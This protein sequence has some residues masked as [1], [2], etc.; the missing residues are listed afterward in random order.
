MGFIDGSGPVLWQEGT[1]EVEQIT[2][3]VDQ[4]DAVEHVNT[5]EE[6]VVGIDQIIID[7]GILTYKCTK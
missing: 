4:G 6:K 1:L 5:A 2:T 3:L 7:L